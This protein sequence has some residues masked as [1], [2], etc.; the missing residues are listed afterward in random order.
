MAVSAVIGAVSAVSAGVMANKQKNATNDASNAAVAQAQK[1]QEAQ[2]ANANAQRE[3]AERVQVE[4]MAFEKQ[5]A[6]AATQ[7]QA[8][9]LAQQ[10]QQATDATLGAQNNQTSTLTPTVQLAAQGDGDAGSAKTR[11]RRAQFRPEYSSGVTI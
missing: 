8:A 9:M 5:R 1:D 3:Q 2:T 4:Q 6:E 11:A 7:Q 10:Q